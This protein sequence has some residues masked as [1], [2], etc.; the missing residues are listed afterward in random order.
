VEFRTALKPDDIGET[1]RMHGVTYARERGF[2]HTF[3]AFVA[4]PL[5]EFAQRALPR[6]RI[7]LADGE[8]RL[9][10][11]IAIVQAHRDTAQLRWFLVDP[12]ARGRGVGRS[13][14]AAAIEFARR[15]KYGGI[16]L[17]TEIELPAAATCTSRR[18]S[19]GFSSTRA[20]S[21]G[22]EVVEEK[23]EMRL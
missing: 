23:Y 2:D 16:D 7:W 19:T 8:D 22:V 9:I 21:G 11:V 17:W 3:E 14:L 15:A 13:L 1:A 6:E 20:G 10:G 12:A 5:A 4:G 18:C